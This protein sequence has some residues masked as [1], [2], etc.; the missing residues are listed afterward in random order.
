[1]AYCTDAFGQGLQHTGRILFRP[2]RIG[3]WFKMAVLN[4][5]VLGF[6]NL[7]LDYGFTDPEKIQ[8]ILKNIERYTVYLPMILAGSLIF[9]V[10]WLIVSFFSSAARIIFL[11]GVRRSEIGIFASYSRHDSKI[12]TYFLWNVIMPMVGTVVMVVILFLTALFP[13]LVELMAGPQIGTIATILV[14]VLIFGL[15]LLAMLFYEIIMN[16]FV[17]PQ[18]VFRNQGIFSSWR[19]AFS[20]IFGNFWEFLGYAIIRIAVY[21]GVLMVTLFASLLVW[22]VYLVISYPL[23]GDTQLTF[24]QS[25]VMAFLLLPLMFGVR[26]VLLPIPAFKDAFALAYLAGITGDET[27]FPGAVPHHEADDASPA[28]SISTETKSPPPF[29]PSDGP[30]LFKD[31]PEFNTGAVPRKAM[32]ELPWIASQEDST[33]PPQPDN[34]HEMPTEEGHDPQTPLS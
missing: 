7:Q 12:V 2:W 10:L 20:I 23:F 31:I 26:F 21:M 5:V 13:M 14:L 28:V 3:F 18:M 17:L 8:D 15:A 19:E 34:T 32:D 30:V 29:M 6:S 4:F 25:L 33:K 9:F 1:M 27:F 11:E 24:S 16:T 22:L